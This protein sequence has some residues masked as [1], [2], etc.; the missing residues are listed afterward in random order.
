MTV[1]WTKNSAEITYE[2]LMLQFNAYV[3]KLS[4]D[5]RAKLA[6]ARDE[7]GLVEGDG[8]TIMA[9][10]HPAKD[11]WLMYFGPWMVANMIECIHS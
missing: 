5:D 10:D 2:D 4:D 11:V 6:Q 7:V 9:D 3:S 1:K 8:V